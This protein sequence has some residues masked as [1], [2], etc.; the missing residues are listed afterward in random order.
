MALLKQASKV[1]LDRRRSLA[2]KC[3]LR[4]GVQL[5]EKDDGTVTLKLVV[6]RGS[7]FFELFRPAVTEKTYE[8]DEFG[9]FV[10]LEIRRRRTVLD[11]V[12][13]FE[14][15]FGLTHRES[16][17]GVVAFV[18]TLIERNVVTVVTD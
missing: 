11:I 17:L 3:L 16:E 1:R 4:E 13:G 6:R 15:R 5:T 7:G 2:G 12:E 10:I 18:K 8:L 9:S 14:K